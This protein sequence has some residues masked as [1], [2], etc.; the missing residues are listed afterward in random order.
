M[1][2]F[3]SAVHE[4]SKYND[5]KDHDLSFTDCTSFSIMNDLSISRVFTF[6]AHFQKAGFNV[7]P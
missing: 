1:E 2:I 4:L 5:K 3:D 6:D 7:L